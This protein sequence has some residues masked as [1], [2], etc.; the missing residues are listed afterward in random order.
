MLEQDLNKAVRSITPSA[1]LR[2][3]VLSAAMERACA[4]SE[5]AA[6]FDRRLTMLDG[7]RPD[8]INEGEY[9]PDYYKNMV[10]R[11]T[12]CDPGDTDRLQDIVFTVAK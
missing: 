11:F 12:L 4:L 5:D 1:E 2:S 10:T 8:I 7:V 9:N 3:R 6:A